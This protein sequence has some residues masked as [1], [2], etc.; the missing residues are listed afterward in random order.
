MRVVV[1]AL[2]LLSFYLYRALTLRLTSLSLSPPLFS[3]SADV[4]TS[5]EPF[6]DPQT[7]EIAVTTLL[8][9][10]NAIIILILFSFFG[11]ELIGLRQKSYEKE[12]DVF[13]VASAVQTRAQL[14]GR[15]MRTHG[16][17][18]CHPNGVAI[19]AA[20]TSITDT[21][22]MWIDA[23]GAA[24]ASMEPPTLILPVDSFALL[25]SGA[26]FH[27]VHKKSGHFSATET[28]PHDVGG[29]VCGGGATQDDDR[30]VVQGR[31][32]GDIEMAIQ[33]VDD[34]D[35][36]HRDAAAD[37]AGGA[38]PAD[39]DALAGAGGDGALADAGAPPGGA[40]ALA[41]P[42]LLAGEQGTVAEL[43]ALLRE[44]DAAL[45]ERDVAL[46]ERDAAL[47]ESE[48][49]NAQLKEEIEALRM[50]TSGAVVHLV[51]AADGPDAASAT[52]GATGAVG[53]SRPSTTPVRSASTGREMLNPLVYAPEGSQQENWEEEESQRPPVYAFL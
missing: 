40:G 6:G 8:I 37:D 4:A 23:E 44:R 24:S 49:E 27:W 50:Q 26:T 20:P 14:T 45:Q 51:V 12:R 1:S 15:G 5:N 46:Q 19:S 35:A 36:D 28:K 53:A 30:V 7:I 21:V 48:A 2:R 13:A 11:S 34:A 47:Q 41:A 33:H 43:Q 22:W 16:Q 39:A 31:V 42:A 17:R 10:V 52:V 18:W 25:P 32:Q 3:A 9:I 29:W 38:V